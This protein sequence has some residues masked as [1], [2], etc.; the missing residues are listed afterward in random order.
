MEKKYQITMK[1]NFL[2]IEKVNTALSYIRSAAYQYSCVRGSYLQLFLRV[3]KRLNSRWVGNI[4][5]HL[6]CKTF[7]EPY[8]QGISKEIKMLKRI[9]LRKLKYLFHISIIL[10]RYLI[11]IYIL[12]DDLL[13]LTDGHRPRITK[14]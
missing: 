10:L 5:R 9:L 1:T 11:D 7:T 8:T 4:F 3:F 14:C 6:S 2:R 13:W 12:F